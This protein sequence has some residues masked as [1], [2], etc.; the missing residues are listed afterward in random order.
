VSLPRLTLRPPA[1]AALL[2]VTVPVVELPPETLAGFTL[3]E[4][5]A[6]AVVEVIVNVPV[7][8]LPW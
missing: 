4:E 5:S 6:T 1:G 2:I 3:T 8:L 7:L